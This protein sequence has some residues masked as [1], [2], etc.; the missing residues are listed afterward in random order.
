MGVEFKEENTFTIGKRKKWQDMRFILSGKW[1][2][3]SAFQNIPDIFC[4]GLE[5]CRRLLKI[6]YVFAVHLMR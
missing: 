6:Q 4:T 5:N 3:R 1:L 2:V